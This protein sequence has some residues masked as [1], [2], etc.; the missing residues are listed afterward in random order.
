MGFEGF[1]GWSGFEFFCSPVFSVVSVVFADEV[2]GSGEVGAV[3]D[4][5][6][7]VAFSDATDGSA[8][9]GFGSD[10]SDACAG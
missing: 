2:Y 4:D 6:D 7:E 8:C 5:F 10:V 9:E 1:G 3:D